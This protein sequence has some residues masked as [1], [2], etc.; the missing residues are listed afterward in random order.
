MAGGSD[1]HRSRCQWINHSYRL[2]RTGSAQAAWDN[3]HV[4]VIPSS[5]PGARSIAAAITG[6][7][8]D[9]RSAANPDG[10]GVASRVGAL[11]WAL[12][13]RSGCPGVTSRLCT[14]DRARC[15]LSALL[16]CDVGQ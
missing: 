12:C 6:A 16:V 11:L 9:Y 14:Y 1:A 8:V 7:V 5:A 15:S 4:D 2:V 3:P 13:W 10:R